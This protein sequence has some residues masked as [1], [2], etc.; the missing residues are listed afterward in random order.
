MIYKVS[1]S[2]VLGIQCSSIIFITS[3]NFLSSLSS[4]SFPHTQAT[5][6]PSLSPSLTGRFLSLFGLIGSPAF[7]VVLLFRNI[8][9]N[10]TATMSLKLLPDVPITFVHAFYFPL[11]FFPSLSSSCTLWSVD[12]FK[13]QTNKCKQKD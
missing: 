13:T 9:H 11:N 5:S 2:G 7:S 6:H 4:G 8:D 3:I 1:H 10:S 12:Q